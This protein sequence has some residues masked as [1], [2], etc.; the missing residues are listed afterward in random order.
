MLEFET[1]LRCDQQ[2]SSVLAMLPRHNTTC[3]FHQSERVRSEIYFEQI[4]PVLTQN[5]ECD[6]VILC[7]RRRVLFL[8]AAALSWNIIR[9]NLNRLRTRILMVALKRKVS[10][11]RESKVSSRV[12]ERGKRRWA[13][14]WLAELSLGQNLFHTPRVEEQKIVCW[15]YRM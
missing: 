8:S 6:F 5:S 7:R 2:A 9:N 10:K 4:S 11:R 3:F 13:T 15:C 14:S 1:N 12:G